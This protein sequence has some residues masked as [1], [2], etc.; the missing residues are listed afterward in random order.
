MTP[1]WLTIVRVVYRY[2]SGRPLDGRIRTDC[3]YFR[4][5]TKILTKNGHASRWAH[6]PGWYRQAWRLGIPTLVLALLVAYSQAPRLTVFLLVLGLTG[7]GYLLGRKVYRKA[8]TWT[9]DRKV[10]KPLAAALEPYT[11]LPATD[12][13][14]GMLLPTEAH[15]EIRV[16][17]APH[18][19]GTRA[20]LED[21]ARITRQRLGGEWDTEVNLRQAPFYLRFTPTPA[22]PEKVT[23]DMVLSDILATTE[24]RPVLGLGSRGEVIH[25]DFDGEIAHLAASIGTGGGK[26]SF[27]RFLVAQF[28]HH[29]VGSFDVCDVK[30]VSLQ[31]MEQVPGL[32]IHRTVDEITEAIAGLK[33][34]MDDRY[35]ILRK[36]SSRVFPRR[37]IL[38]EEQNAFATLA[39]IAWKGAGN[40]G[41]HPVWDDIALLLTMGRQVNMNIIGVYQRM[42]AT[43]AGGGDLRDQYGLK[44]LSRFSHQAWDVLVGTRP[45]GVSS[46]IPG[47]AIAVMGGIQRQVQLPFITVQEAMQLALSGTPVTVTVPEY[48]QVSPL[49]PVTVT[50]EEPR[51]TLAEAARQEWCTVSYD[52][53]KQRVSRGRK[54]GRLTTA[55]NYTK[56]ELVGIL[57]GSTEPATGGGSR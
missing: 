36:N 2:L 19:S 4:P 25:L 23:L 20:A 15:P 53:L 48:Q 30:Q 7:T 29:G 12:C 6:R 57:T 42:S 8:L 22:P 44:V 39:R 31:G 45:R 26:S 43:A 40:R 52:A 34:E 14:A 11:G 27:L 10:V 41:N 13:R 49:S 28:A 54:A 56:D 5:G 24:A 21:I 18:H 38:L 33:K 35:S 55:E 46:A 47:R 37:V 1:V 32:R 3:G 16:P 50:K 17:L 51:Y 9:Y